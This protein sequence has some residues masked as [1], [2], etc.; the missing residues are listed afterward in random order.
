MQK[1]Q[2]LL[3]SR[4]LGRGVRLVSFT[5]DPENDSPGVLNQYARRYE[6][7]PR[8]WKFLTGDRDEIW[9]LSKKGFKLPVAENPADADMPI[10]HTSKFV[11]VDRLGRIRAYYDGLSDGG[12]QS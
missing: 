9:E 5:V 6:A 4:S 12:A 10:F 11:L 3:K 8:K 7:D 2:R 1:L